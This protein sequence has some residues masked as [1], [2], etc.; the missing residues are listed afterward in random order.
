MRLIPVFL[1]IIMVTWGFVGCA[2]QG[3]T[4]RQHYETATWLGIVGA[5]VGALIDQDNP[6]RGATIGAA[7]GSVTGYGLTEIQQRAAREAVNRHQTVTYHNPNTD[8]WVQADPVV[9]DHGYAKVRTRSWSG[10]RLTDDNYIR[11]PI[12]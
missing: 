10:R 4:T 3:P 7:I 8:Q 12:Y 1:I 9:Y 5:G 6:W 11:L 2:P